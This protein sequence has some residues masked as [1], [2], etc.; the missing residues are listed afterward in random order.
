MRPRTCE[1]AEVGIAKKYLEKKAVER[2]PT[3]VLD[4]AGKALIEGVDR[5]VETRCHAVGDNT[6]GV[7]LILL[8]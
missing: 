3:P 2:V 4:A 8:G 1:T 7:E 6:C 5:A